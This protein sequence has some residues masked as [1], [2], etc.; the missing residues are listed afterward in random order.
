MATGQ[1]QLNVVN[2]RRKP[3]DKKA[4]LLVT[5]RD[6]TQKTA[7][8]RFVDG[9]ET[10]DPFELEVNDNLADRYTV[11]VS[12]K[13]HTDGGFTPVTIKAGHTEPL[14]LMLVPRT[15]DFQ[16][17]P[18]AKLGPDLVSF[19]EGDTRGGQALYDRMAAND[20]PSLACLL[21][22]TT[23]LEQMTLVAHEDLDP[24]PLKSFKALDADRPLSQDRIFAWADARL[25]TQIEKTADV[26]GTSGVSRIA[27]APA[28]LHKGASK[29]FKQTDFGEANVQLSFHET[30]PTP[31]SI[32]GVKC[33]LVDVDIDYFQDTA[34]HLLGEVFPNKLKSLIFGKHSS[35]SLTDP[36]TVYGL[37]WTA[38]KRLNRDF[39]PPYVI[40]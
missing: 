40:A 29:S 34:A 10:I 4:E 33:L 11:L 37:R 23:A 22:I 21:N 1:I 25:L 2:G 24:N 7:I 18:V 3:F 9:S 17:E 36:G 8:R 16:F 12:T 26:K 31:R 6:G 39:A 27:T 5:A 13:G 30:D 32:K 28:G 35:K 19:L 38:G 15:M 20:K 14:D